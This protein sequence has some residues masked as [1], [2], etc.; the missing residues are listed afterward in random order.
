MN[1]TT[2]RKTK[3]YSV[4]SIPMGESRPTILQK[5]DEYGMWVPGNLYI[6][7]TAEDGEYDSF[8][9]AL[10]DAMEI[11]VKAGRIDQKTADK[12]VIGDS[13]MDHLDAQ[14]L[15]YIQLKLK[16]F[17]QYVGKIDPARAEKLLPQAREITKQLLDERIQNK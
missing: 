17:M 2:H 14:W 12:Y 6:T 10:I 11:G 4:Y 5:K 16:F 13:G 7:W 1:W 3:T 15:G 8:L 9:D